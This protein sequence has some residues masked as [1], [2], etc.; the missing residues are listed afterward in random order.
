MPWENQINLFQSSQLALFTL[1]GGKCSPERQL[2]TQLSSHRHVR[3]RM[4][5]SPRILLA[6]VSTWPRPETYLFDLL[7]IEQKYKS[8]Y[9]AA[10][11]GEREQCA[12]CNHR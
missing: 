11:I 5:C 7:A 1:V 10:V 2:F 12:H 9:R 3:L 4:D 8:S 6:H